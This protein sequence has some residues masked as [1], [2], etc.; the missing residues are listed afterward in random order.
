MTKRKESE[1]DKLVRLGFDGLY[2]PSEPC[3]CFIGDLRPCG[4]VR[5][6]CRGGLAF[7]GGVYAPRFVRIVKKTGL[8]EVSHG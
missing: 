3:G 2:H 7:D 5:T 4:E 8:S 6:G 1:A